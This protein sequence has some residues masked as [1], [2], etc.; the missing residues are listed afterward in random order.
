MVVNL[1]L[2]G[3]VFFGKRLKKERLFQGFLENYMEFFL[4]F[5][6]FFYIS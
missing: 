2:G 6:F 5:I 4:H 3:R 1:L